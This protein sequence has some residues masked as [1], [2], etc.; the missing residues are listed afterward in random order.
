MINTDRDLFLSPIIEYNDI[1]N[2]I[3]EYNDIENLKDKNLKT[4][5]KNKY[6][7]RKRYSKSN[8]D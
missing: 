1:E 6:S 5:G 2:L 7:S 3:I 8:F 4:F